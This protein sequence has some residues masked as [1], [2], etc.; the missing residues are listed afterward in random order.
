MVKLAGEV[1][2]LINKS[3]K[4]KPSDRYKRAALTRLDTHLTEEYLDDLQDL[5]PGRK[6]LEE[7]AFTNTKV[8]T[9]SSSAA[10]TEKNLKAVRDFVKSANGTV[11]AVLHEVKEQ[12]DEVHRKVNVSATNTILIPKTQQAAL[13]STIASLKSHMQ[14]MATRNKVA[15]SHPV[16]IE[17]NAIVSE[18]ETLVEDQQTDVFDERDRFYDDF[19]KRITFTLKAETV[20]E[21]WVRIYPDDI[22]IDNHDERITEEEERIAQDYYYEVYSKPPSDREGHKLGA[23]RA[24]AASLGVRRAAYIIKAILPDEVENDSVEDRKNGVLNILD[25]INNQ[26]PFKLKKRYLETPLYLNEKLEEV[27][28]NLPGVLQNTLT[29]SAFDCCVENKS[30]LD[31]LLALLKWIFQGFER[32]MLGEKLDQQTIDGIKLLMQVT[33]NAAEIVVLFYKNNLEALNQ[34]YKP[35]LTFK[36]VEKKTKSWDRA[37]ITEVMP[38]RFAVVT[39]RGE[40]YI[41]AVTGK[42]ILKPL[43]VSIDPSGDQA[44]RFVHLPN[45]DLEVPE[46]IR[47]LFD[48]DAAVDAGMAVRIPLQDEDF[49]NGFDLVMAVGV[50]NTD[51][52]TGQ[53]VLNKLLTNHLYSSG[54][55]EYLP[56]GTA[57]NNTEHVKSPYKAIDNDFDAAFDLFFNQS[58][59]YYSYSLTNELKMTDGQ[60]FRDALGLPDDIANIIRHHDKLDIAQGRAMNRA[61]Y[62]STLKYYFSIMIDNLMNGNDIGRTLPYLMEHVSAVGTVPSFHIDGQP[63]GLLPITPYRDFKVSGSTAKGTEGSYYKN[64][65]IFL[66]ATRFGFDNFTD[67]PQTINGQKYQNDPQKEFIKILGLEPFL[68]RILL[69]FW[70]KLVQPLE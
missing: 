25:D 15:A 62:N 14:N 60:M 6:T 46:E 51:E 45:G 66:N 65:T 23:Y 33:Q 22:A 28:K 4:F 53:N 5:L 34:A 43:Q 61:L 37:G 12:L 55:M 16:F 38:D 49:E 47:W 10:K 40:Q 44:E 39:K 32:E 18:L 64:L 2:R 26:L 48:F 29:A 58:P 54:G 31:E 20:K 11:D 56:V 21:L 30:S 1:Q 13:R 24:A 59:T 63:Y 50:Q 17:N 35:T 42:Q 70:Y 69:P 8:R 41:H 57:T 67:K 9:T 36:S 68:E 19:K 52:Q 7:Q 27:L 3:K